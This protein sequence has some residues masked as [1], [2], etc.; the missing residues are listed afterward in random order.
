MTEEDSCARRHRGRA[1]RDE[2]RDRRPGRHARAAPGGAAGGRP[3][4]ARGRAGPRQDPDRAHARRR[5]RRL[6]PPHPV[7]A[8]PRARRPRRHPHLPAGLRPLRHR[9]GAG[10][11]QLPARRRDQPR[12]GQGAV[13]A[14][15]GDAGA[16]GDHRRRHPP[17]AVAVP[18]AR[19]A[20]PDRVRGH[21]PAARGAGRPLPAQAA[22]RLP[23]HGRGGGGGGPL[24]GARAG[25]RGAAVDRGPRALL[26]RGQARVRGARRDRLRR[27]AG[28]CH[29]PPRPLR[30]R[31]HREV[32]RVR[33]LAARADRP[34]RG[35]AGAGAAARAPARGRLRRARSRARRA[36]PPARAV[37]RGAER[38]RL[39][40]RPARPAARRRR[41]AR[42][43]DAAEAA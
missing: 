35:L 8:R 40:R 33:L 31:R 42:R 4:A 11:R 6:L 41:P 21:V 15:R 12:A 29:A 28:G 19:H 26:G 43:D 5:A 1:L 24:A 20:E 14:A 34:D 9:A 27:P 38:R 25:D 16:P 32:H 30:A 23:G 7:H 10:V 37:V 3:C 13:G 18:G 39:A 22:R 2:A 17:G 36:A